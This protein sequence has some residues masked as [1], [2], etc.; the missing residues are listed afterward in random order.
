MIFGRLRHLRRTAFVAV[1]VSVQRLRQMCG[2]DFITACPIR[3]GARQ[4]QD[5][6]PTKKYPSL[7]KAVPK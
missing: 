1:Q 6:I 5:V 7:R 3:D 2:L 4:F